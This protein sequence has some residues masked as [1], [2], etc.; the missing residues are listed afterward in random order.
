MTTELTMRYRNDNKA[1]T[2]RRYRKR[3]RVATRPKAEPTYFC[4]SAT[5]LTT[6]QHECT[7]FRGSEI[8][9][10]ITLDVM[11]HGVDSSALYPARFTS[12]PAVKLAKGLRP[13]TKIHISKGRFDYRPI[14][15]ETELRIVEFSVL[16]NM[17]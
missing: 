12:K 3:E 17:A 10:E 5:V 11:I 8:R 2:N 13:G 1:R 4:V 16:H 15:S 9:P 14:R 7:V 6:P